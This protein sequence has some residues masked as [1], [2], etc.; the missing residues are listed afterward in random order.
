[1]R[2]CDGGIVNNVP[3][4]VAWDS[5]QQGTLG[6]RNAY[7]VAADVFAPVSSSRNLLWVPIQQIARANVLA[8]RPYSDFHKTFPNP[9]SPLQVIVN[10]YSRLKTIVQ[11]AR[12]E[13]AR[14]MPYMK[15]A[16]EPLPPY[17]IWLNASES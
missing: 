4:Q 10:Q 14:D 17:G 3:S 6:T 16:L 13:F 2:L 7:I 1:M 5:V 12:D 11:S 8:N 9:P 15:R